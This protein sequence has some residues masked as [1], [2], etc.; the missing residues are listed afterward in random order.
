MKQIEKTFDLVVCGGGCAGLCAAIAAARQG[1]RVALVHDRPVLGGNSSSEIGVSVHGAAQFHA[2]ARETG[3]IS[4]MLIEERTRNHKRIREVGWQNAP[5][6]LVQYEWVQAEENLELFLNTR[7]TDVV[8]ADGSRGSD[9]SDDPAAE[10]LLAPGYRLRPAKNTCR[11]VAAVE[12]EVMSAETRLVLRGEYF[13]DATGDALVADLAGCEWRMGTEG[14]EEFDEP[15]APARPSTDVMGNTIAFRCVDTGAPAPFK[16]PE[17]AAYYDDADFFYQQ[18]RI[19]R[20]PQGGYWWIEIGVPWNTITDAE[21]IRR[22]LTRHVLGVWDWMKHRDPVMKDR[23]AN[24]ALDWI[25]QVP[26]KRESRRVMGHHLLTEHDVTER[27]VFQ[28]EIAFGGWFVDLHTPGGLLAGSSEPTSVDGLNNLSDYARQSYVGPY[29]IPLRSCLSKDIDN[30][31][32]AG[33]NVSATHAALGTIRVQGTTALMGQGCGTAVAIAKREGF[34]LS[35]L[36][37]E[38]SSDLRQSL[39]RQG[40]FLPSF[41]NEDPADLTRQATANASSER[42]FS[43]AAPGS[44]W[45]SGGLA[46]EWHRK[47]D[48]LQDRRGQ[49]IALGRPELRKISVCLRNKSNREQRVRAWIVPSE[50]IWDYRVDTGQIFAETELI[51]PVNDGKPVWVEWACGLSAADG[52]EAGHYVRLDLAGNENLDWITSGSIEYGLIAHF[53]HRKGVLRCFGEGF[54]LS[55][56]V[57]PAQPCYSPAN[58][59]SGFTRPH[60][61]TNV[62]LSDPTAGLPQWL[63]LAWEVPQEIAQVEL[64]FPGNLTREYHC[65]PPFFRDPLTVKDYRIEAQTEGA[66]QTLLRVEGNYQRHCVH[67]LPYPITTARLRICI[68]ATNG[69]PSAAIHEV[70]CYGQL[71]R[72]SAHRAT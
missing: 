51:V 59:L 12:A 64:T 61:F 33:R 25:G 8:M 45:I 15:H 56:R 20:D 43:G 71:R 5:W 49:L 24:Y 38:R 31:M 3:I 46:E 35:Q 6:D 40:C 69:D 48:A 28:D 57:E 21:D 67:P 42:L 63:E 29:G 55:H 52:L 39:L 27:R 44:T 30:L 7:V 47:N 23:T 70:R 37:H 65:S 1:V 54:T 58:L 4:E 41:R 62:W 16:A 14:R 13:L 19:C 53:E 36:V 72:S 34:S 22:E 2:Y 10:G 11:I 9:H 32:M 50:G 66:W 68:D 60:R 18:G 17:W 26:G